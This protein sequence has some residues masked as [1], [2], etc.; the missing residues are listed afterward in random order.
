MVKLSIGEL[1]R[2]RVLETYDFT[3]SRHL[4]AYLNEMLNGM[5]LLKL[6]V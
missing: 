1:N 5:C 3:V 2:K 6:Y 4:I